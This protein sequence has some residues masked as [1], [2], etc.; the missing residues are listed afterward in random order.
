MLTSLL[1]PLMLQVGPNPQTG[2]IPDYSAEVQD[3]PPRE[4]SEIVADRVAPTWLEECFSLV[5]SDPARAHVKAQL[6]RDSSTGSDRILANHCLGLAATALGRWEE[7]QLAFLTARNEAPA[8]DFAFRARLGAM[9]ANAVM[10]SG[11]IEAALGLLAQAESDARASASGDLI[12]LTM[13]DKA[14]VLV[15]LG[16]LDE[17]EA[18]L[19]EAARLRPRD[20]EA[21]LLL[22]TLLRRM[23]RLDEAQAMIV[24]AN[25]GAE[26]G[27][28]VDLE[29]GVIAALQGRE[30]DARR[31]WQTIVDE[32]PQSPEAESARTYLAQLGPATPTE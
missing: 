9:A 20:A 25:E 30:A 23:D 16:R 5:D 22:A 10:P 26:P 2:A 6:Q 27:A 32:A 7:A 3:R 12:A 31:H 8:E 17:A 19:S 11:D 15:A 1:L 21:S 4:R 13:M 29:A 24:Q 28:Q 14:R 18:P